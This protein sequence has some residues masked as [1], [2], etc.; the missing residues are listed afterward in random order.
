MLGTSPDP[1]QDTKNLDLL[2]VT[3]KAYPATPERR[4]HEGMLKPKDPTWHDRVCNVTTVDAGQLV[5][6]QQAQ[7]ITETWKLGRGP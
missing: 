3:S 4:R 1:E 5:T 7:S 6:T 2:T